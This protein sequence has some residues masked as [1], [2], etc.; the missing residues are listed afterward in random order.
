MLLGLD[1]N[2]I[3]VAI[4][5]ITTDFRSLSDIAWYGS[6][7]LLT[8]TAFQPLFG[9]LYKFFNTKTVYLI[10]L[11]LFEGTETDKTTPTFTFYTSSSV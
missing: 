9:N 7:Y 11:L 3:G 4:P 6:A 5:R 10:S 8:M 1:M 2:I